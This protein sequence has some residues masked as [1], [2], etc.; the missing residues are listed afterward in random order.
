[1]LYNEYI[2][3]YTYMYK[4]YNILDGKENRELFLLLIYLLECN[5]YFF[6]S[7]CCAVSLFHI[8][9]Y[10]NI[11][12]LVYFPFHLMIYKKK[13]KNSG[14]LGTEVCLNKYKMCGSS[15]F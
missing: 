7:A 6:V 10:I 4:V 2:Y 1:M 15:R 14:I 9:I 11:S 12:H 13:K 8:Y 5:T 3:L